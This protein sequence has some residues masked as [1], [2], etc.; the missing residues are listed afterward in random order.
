MIK[1][2]LS[3]VLLIL[4][5]NLIFFLQNL[6][7]SELQ[8]YFIGFRLNLF[9]IIF[10]IL[11]Y[12]NQNKLNLSIPYL[13]NFGKIKNWFYVFVIPTLS[14]AITILI[15]D[16]L[17]T[18]KYKKP[19]FLYEFGLT[20]L[21]DIPIY[22]LW[23]L[24]FLLSLLV[25]IIILIEKF[26]FLR[27]LLFSFF[28]NF[29]FLSL[30]TEKFSNKIQIEEFSFFILTFAMIFYNQSVLRLFKSIW[31]S[32]FSILISIYSYVL[33]FGSKSSFVIKTFFART[34]SEWEGIFAIRK[35]NPEII[36]IIFASSIILFG[37]FFFIFE[38]RKNN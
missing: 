25:L 23:N 16:Q 38:P 22:Y 32:I 24:P 28:L 17:G 33:V 6:L 26:T 20:S 9:L 5:C 31:I 21:I 11:I 27:A 15:I 37:I 29:S 3:I 10:L 34:Y 18:L 8:F 2:I 13:K 14:A 35:V 30:L 12:F 7:K 36:D 4:F 1:R 19:D